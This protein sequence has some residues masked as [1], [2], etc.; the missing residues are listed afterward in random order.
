VMLSM[1]MSS[2]PSWRCRSRGDAYN[3]DTSGR[4]D[5]CCTQEKNGKSCHS[6]NQRTAFNQTTGFAGEESAHCI[7][8]TVVRLRCC[9]CFFGSGTDLLSLLIYYVLVRV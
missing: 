3:A 6:E 8:K 5:D 7:Y 4:S 1:W 2:W 9:Y